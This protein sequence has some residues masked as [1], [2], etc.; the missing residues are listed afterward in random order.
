MVD[1]ASR[2]M[3]SPVRLTNTL[4][5]KVEELRTVE[6]GVVRLYTCGPTVYQYA[7]IGNLR[8]Y[9]NE[10]FVRRALEAAGYDVRH[11]MNITDVGHLQHDDVEAG[12]DKMSLAAQREHKDPWQ[13]ARFYEREFLADTAK[14]NIEPP[15]VVPRATEHVEQ[16]IEFILALEEGGYTYEVDGNV[17]FEVDRF[18]AYGELARLGARDE[19][20]IA[21]VEADPRKRNPRD[22]VLWF[23][24]SK[25]PNQIMRWDSPWGSGFP[26]WHIECSAMGREYLGD[27]VD[28]HM[29]GIDHIPVHHTNEIAQSDSRLGHRWVTQ[30]AH[31]GW[32][33]VDDA[34][35]A[36]SEGNF[37]RLATLEEN[38]FDPLHYRYFCAQAHY[39]SE[40][41]FTLESLAAAREAFETLVSHVVDWRFVT[42]G[43][44]L[45]PRAREHSDAF[46]ASA[47]DDFN[48]PRAL[49]TMWQV[50]RDAELPPGEKL[51]LMRDFDRLLGFRVDDMHREELPDELL[52]LVREREQARDGRDWARADALRDELLGHGIQ[53]KDSPDGTIWY[54]TRVPA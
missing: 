27:R 23:S 2:A 16:M 40:Q 32:L 20:E 42:D 52:A 24:Q 3:P 54:R 46:W 47:W 13:I 5:R 45:G 11:V 8:T 49:A 22:F 38:G 37:L 7:H 51:T 17:Y 9:V 28:L 18:P 1:L 43:E 29:G 30:W 39:R 6:D 19:D 35:M 25:F 41:K 10:D 21:R 15:T 26:G 12:E 53:L 50:V 34:K 4:T 14:L 31:C 44:E 48:L 33:L 36:K